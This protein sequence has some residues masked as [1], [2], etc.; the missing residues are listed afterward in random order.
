[1]FNEQI[2][3]PD[4]SITVNAAHEY[5]L[6][7]TAV[8]D[9]VIGSSTCGPLTTTA[10]PHPDGDGDGVED[11]L[12]NCPAVANPT[13]EDS[14]ADGT[15]DACDSTPFPPTA[16]ADLSVTL[17]DSA[18]P[19][20]VRTQYNYTVSVTNSGPDTATGVTTLTKLT[21][22]KFVS[23]SAPCVVVKGENGGIRC[24]FGEMVS[25]ATATVTL[26]VAAGTKPGTATASS[27]VSSTSSDPDAGNN[28]ATESTTVV[29][30]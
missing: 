20:N 18:D 25:G 8:G 6:G 10:V 4:G 12:D 26:T 24:D 5:L 28:T 23:S 11:A 1:M 2:A 15:G 29:R 19:A 13:Q 30:P 9:M 14:D 7:P 27:T 16:A 22:A 17:A 3:N 21:G